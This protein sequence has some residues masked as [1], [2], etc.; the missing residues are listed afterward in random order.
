MALI[1]EQERAILTEMADVSTGLCAMKYEVNRFSE[2]LSAH[3]NVV[4]CITQYC[5]D[6]LFVVIG[7]QRKLLSRKMSKNYI[8]QI[9]KGAVFVAQLRLN[10]VVR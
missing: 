5:I 9:A 8:G 7:E 3:S 1:I 2:N 10:F 6:S 4:E